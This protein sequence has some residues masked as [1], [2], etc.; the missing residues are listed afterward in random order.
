MQVQDVRSRLVERARALGLSADSEEQLLDALLDREVTVAPPTDDECRRW[1]AE[2]PELFRS[3]DL[4]EA[5]HILFAVTD[6]VPLAPLRRQAQQVLDE[7]LAAPE[8]F[9]ELARQFSNCPSAQVGG[10]LGQLTRGEV[11]PELWQAVAAFAGTGIV[12]TLVE[13]R[14]GLHVLRVSRRIEGCALPYEMVQQK[15]ATRLAEQN[16]HTALRDYAHALMHEA[17]EAPAAAMPP[18][19]EHAPVAA[20]RTI[21]AAPLSSAQRGE[22]AVA[23]VRRPAH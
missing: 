13:T 4:I 15:I 17:E 1:Y 12:P 20:D 5:D 6:N 14:Y 3:G 21:A 8:R 23:E 19:H 11:V 7:A 10:N 18:L 2:H 9:G 16:L 22:M